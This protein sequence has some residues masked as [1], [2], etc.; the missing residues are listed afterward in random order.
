MSNKIKAVVVNRNLLTTLKNTVEF[1]SKEPRVEV[2]IYDQKSTYPPLLEYYKT[3]NVLYNTEN[4]GPHSVW[5]IPN[6][7]KGHYIVTDSDCIYDGVPTD[8]LDKMLE[9]LNI[10]DS[11]KVGF[12]LRLDDLPDNKLTRQVKDHESRYW[13]NKCQ[14]GWIADIDTTFALYRPSSGFSYNAVRLSEPYTIK[15][16]PWYLDEN[17][18]DEWKY[19]LEH[20]SGISTWGMKLKETYL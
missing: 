6:V 18:S 8:W 7:N 4:G 10:I 17:M 12:S 19:Y 1:L 16:T 2:I 9:S 20:A 11:N 3:Q 13:I 15:H 5:G 14:F